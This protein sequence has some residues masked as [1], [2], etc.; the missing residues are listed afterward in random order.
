[1]AH[2]TATGEAAVGLLRLDRKAGCRPPLVPST[3]A[4]CAKQQRANVMPGC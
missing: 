1:M 2:E 3:A 4:A